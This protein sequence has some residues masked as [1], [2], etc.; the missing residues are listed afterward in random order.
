MQRGNVL[1]K[2]GDFEVAQADFH[3][4]VGGWRSLN[5][6]IHV[7][8]F[9]LQSDASN[10]EARQHFDLTV[11]LTQRVQE[12]ESAYTTQDYAKTIELLS[13]AIEVDRREIHWDSSLRKNYRF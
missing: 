10:G 8:I 11:Q 4:V 9:Q 13:T 12:A 7:W 2:Q 3:S 6:I 5:L 1:L